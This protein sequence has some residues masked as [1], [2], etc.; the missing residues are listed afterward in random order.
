M[1]ILKVI[2]KKINKN[3]SSRFKYYKIINKRL[4]NPCT[5][6]PIICNF[7]LI[8]LLVIIL[9]IIKE[10]TKVAKDCIPKTNPII[11]SYTLNSAKAYCGK[12]ELR[13]A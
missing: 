11:V 7:F 8:F 10:V 5:T 6:I 2:A 12:Y 9:A 1:P 4:E 3:L 13:I